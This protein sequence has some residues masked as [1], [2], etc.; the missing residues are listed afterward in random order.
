MATYQWRAY[1]NY[2]AED[3]TCDGQPLDH[4]VIPNDGTS[5]K[6]A[7][8]GG[9]TETHT[10]EYYYRD[11][12][13]YCTEG[14][15]CFCNASS[16]RVVFNV[17]ETW[18]SSYNVVTN[19][20]TLSVHTV[21]NSVRRDDVVGRQSNLYGRLIQIYN[22]GG[23]LVATFNETGDQV[24]QAHTISGSIDLGT[25]SITIDPGNIENGVSTLHI[26]NSVPG[27]TS[28]DDIR[29][30]TQFR[31][32][33]PLP[34]TYTLTYSANGGSGAPAAQSASTGAGS[35]SFTVSN[36]APTWGYYEF[37]G[38]SHIQ[39]SDS[40][41]EADVEYVGGDT[42]TL[43]EGSPSLTLYAVWRMTY[44]PG[45]TYRSS[46]GVWYSHDRKPNGA[47]KIYTGSAW[48]S[49]METINGPAG[50]G[51]PPLIKHDDTWHNMRRIGQE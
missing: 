21:L 35:Y 30:G 22:Y 1:T 20:L 23:T 16:S 27:S 45:K 7:T 49:N 47:A 24:T 44:V 11:A 18:T 42:I 3:Y 5:W 51:N 40:R 12:S 28:W 31:N 10:Y 41:T 13:A 37:L 39:Y 36:T 19:K 17:T 43:Q 4:G 8:I 32:T 26:H 6:T 50:T 48:S 34:T 9:A 33:L 38:W 46:D 29:A 15:T 14:A 25:Q 2:S